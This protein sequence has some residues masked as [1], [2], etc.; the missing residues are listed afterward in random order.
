MKYKKM[1]C[2]CLLKKKKLNTLCN[3][4]W[5]HVNPN[6]SLCKIRVFYMKKKIKFHRFLYKVKNHI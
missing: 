5:A 2:V 6:L 4:M 1:T 3:V